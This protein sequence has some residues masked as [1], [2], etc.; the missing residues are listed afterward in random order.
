MR[1][2]PHENI[3]QFHDSYLVRDELWVVMEYMDG[4][5]LT[6]IVQRT[7]YNQFHKPVLLVELVS[8]TSYTSQNTLDVYTDT[9]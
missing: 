4:G 7:R 5:A 6:S 1:D 9:L 2:H 8:I 3:V